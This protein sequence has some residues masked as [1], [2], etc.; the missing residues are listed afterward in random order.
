MRFFAP[1]SKVYDSET[2]GSAYGP[3]GPLKIDIFFFSGCASLC[4]YGSD[5]ALDS[6]IYVSGGSKLDFVFYRFL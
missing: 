5:S 4:P 1:S 2:R 6:F 3:S